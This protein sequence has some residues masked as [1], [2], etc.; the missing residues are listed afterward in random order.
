[1]LR[2]DADEEK[3][4]PAS[5]LDLPKS[6]ELRTLTGVARFTLLKTFLTLAAKLS[7]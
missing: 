1:M 7:E 5:A 4:P 6:G 2:L 3:K